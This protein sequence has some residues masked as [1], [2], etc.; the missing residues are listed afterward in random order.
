MPS[1][2]T[3]VSTSHP[4]QALD[5]VLGVPKSMTVEEIDQVVGMFKQGARVAVEA[6]F[7]G[8]QIHGAHGFLVSQF[9]SP[10]TNRRTDDY[11]GTPYK[12]MAL[13]R[14]LVTELRELVP[15]PLCLAVKLNSA[16]YMGAGR[17]LQMEEGLDQIK[18]LVECGMVDFVEISGGNAENVSSGLHRKM[19]SNGV[20]DDDCLPRCKNPSATRRSTR[21]RSAPRPASARASSTT[22]RR[23]SG[24]SIH[25]FPF[26]SAAV[27]RYN[28]NAPCRSV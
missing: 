22:S 2:P 13:M 14:R 4:S 12:R 3:L 24:R 23:R 5:K 16:D 25:R 15:K 18:W 26:N 7:K 1:W 28:A 19:R 11:G 9:L 8:V 21:R 17:G 6:G 20:H 10:H 27:N